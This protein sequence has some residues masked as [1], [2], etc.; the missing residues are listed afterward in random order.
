MKK[1]G[2]FNCWARKSNVWAYSITPPATTLF[3]SVLSFFPLFS[4]SLGIA[5]PH[6]MVWHKSFPLSFLFSFV[7]F[8]IGLKTPKENREWLIL[9]RVAS[10]WSKHTY[11]SITYIYTYIHKYMHTYIQ[12]NTILQCIYKYVHTYIHTYIHT[13]YT[14]HTQ[15][16]TYIHAY[17]TMHTQIHTYMCINIH[18]LC[19]EIRIYLFCDKCATNKMTTIWHF[20]MFCSLPSWSMDWPS[21]RSLDIYIY[22]YIHTYIIYI[23]DT[24]LV[25]SINPIHCIGSMSDI[26]GAMA[27]IP[28]PILPLLCLL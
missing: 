24:C 27:F 14:M 5:T 9:A 4:L 15:V 18:I 11:Y 7:F 28:L 16:H 20:V 12:Y 25:L 23:C 8:W 21:P 17:Y 6:T 19:E 13:Y 26:Y 10:T 2:R 3:C 1:K 22:I